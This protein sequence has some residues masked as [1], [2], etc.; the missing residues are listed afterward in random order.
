MPVVSLGLYSFVKP[1]VIAFNTPLLY[2]VL[3]VFRRQY[4]VAF[5]LK[6]YFDIRYEP[7]AHF[8]DKS[9]SL[10]IK[11]LLIINFLHHLV[12]ISIDV[13]IRVH[14]SC[15]STPFQGFFLLHP[16]AIKKCLIEYLLLELPAHFDYLPLGVLTAHPK[17]K[18]YSG[19]P[20]SF[21]TVFG[22]IP[23]LAVKQLPQQ[24]KSKELTDMLCLIFIRFGDSIFFF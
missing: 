24:T 16:I 15:P 8:L 14:S 11:L 1:P 13:I 9:F 7:L 12:L 20:I 23:R 2:F 5:I 3:A 4:E 10:P 21:E 18:F 19:S 22:P 17:A 6:G